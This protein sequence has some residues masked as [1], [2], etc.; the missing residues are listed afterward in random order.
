LTKTS[1]RLLD[2]YTNQYVGGVPSWL[3]FAASSVMDNVGSFNGCLTD[4]SV[5]DKRYDLSETVDGRNIDYCNGSGRCVEND[6]SCPQSNQ[7]EQGRISSDSCRN[8]ICQ[9]D[10]DC[11]PNDIGIGYFCD[12]HVG[13]TGRLCDKGETTVET[14]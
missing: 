2:V 12:C 11:V 7:G 4:L 9:K 1:L 5:N 6:N 10:S 8:N 14:L 3:T 13:R